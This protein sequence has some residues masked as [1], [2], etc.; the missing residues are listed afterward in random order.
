MKHKNI[1]Y[2]LFLSVSCFLWACKKELNVYPTTSEI[3]GNVIVDA[4]SASTVLNGVYYRFAN[5]GF[6]YNNI[7][8]VKWVDVNESIPS[9]LANT[10]IIP[11]YDDFNGFTFNSKTYGIDNIWNYGYALVNAANGFLKNV[12]PVTSIPDAAKKQMIA[13]AKFLRAFGN[14]ELL[15]YYGQYNNVSSNYGIIL[16]DEFVTTDNASQPRSTVAAAYTSILADLDAAISGLPAQNTQTFYANATAAKLLKARVLINRGAAGDYAQV[17]T[18]TKDAI[19]NGPF[20]LEASV[21]D[22]FL[23]KGFTSQEVILSVQPFSTENYKFQ[24]YQY[25]QQYVAT[26]K[27]KSLLANDPRN[28]WYYK[29]YQSPY[30]GTLPELTKY[31]SGDI[32]N[33]AQTPLSENC[34]AFRLTEA[35]LLQAEAITLAGGSLADARALLKTVLGHAGVSDFSAVDQATTPAALQLLI[36]QEEMKSFEGENGADWFALRRL[37]F[38]TIKTLQPAIA[39]A[40]QLILPIPDSEIITNNKVIQNPGYGN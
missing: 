23:S 3:D 8:S 19:N 13:E 16:H 32:N 35:Y 39:A 33:I 6:D 20:V 25:Y 31:Y 15:L 1:K 40:N 36:V 21:K 12:A 24:D 29:D 34:Y 18:L 37:P 26:D 17:I 22:L 4:K 14:E 27:L 28:Q 30:Y 5:A 11:G 7:P 9:E 38:A 10:L 2:L